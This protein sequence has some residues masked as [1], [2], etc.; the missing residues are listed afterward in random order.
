MSVKEINSAGNEGEIVEKQERLWKR[1]IDKS[2]ENSKA[3]L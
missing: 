1:M 2:E 3:K